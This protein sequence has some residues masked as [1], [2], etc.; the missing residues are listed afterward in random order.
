LEGDIRDPARTPVAADGRFIGN[1]PLAHS[2][3]S[4]DLAGHGGL[5][6][7]TVTWSEFDMSAV[8]IP[9]HGRRPFS[10][11]ARWP[12]D[13]PLPG[14]VNMNFYDGHVAQVPLE[15]LWQQEWHRDYRPPTKRPRLE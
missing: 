1:F 8:A 4:G 13:R 7:P 10:F 5:L 12:N 9:R 2:P 3:A 15:Q 14:A 11:P 6:Q